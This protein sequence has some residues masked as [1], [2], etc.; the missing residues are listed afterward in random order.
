[1]ISAWGNEL[2]WSL[3]VQWQIVALGILWAHLTKSHPYLKD[4][5]VQC[6]PFSL[7]SYTRNNRE[8]MFPVKNLALYH[9]HGRCW[10]PLS[11]PLWIKK[12]G[13]FSIKHWYSFPYICAF[14]HPRWEEL[15]WEKEMRGRET[16]RHAGLLK[17][18]RLSRDFKPLCW[19]AKQL[20]KSCSNKTL[21]LHCLL[22]PF[23]GSLSLSNNYSG[24]VLASIG[25]AECNQPYQQT[26]THSLVPVAKI[27]ICAKS[28]LHHMMI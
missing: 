9:H 12:R 23:A 24:S 26:R 2:L 18:T 25:L 7:G 19:E 20:Q 14:K 22:S 10:N 5:C 15:R 13:G 21:I 1:M 16:G 11:S 17:S 4:R 28:I 27:I 8:G 6:N 3:V